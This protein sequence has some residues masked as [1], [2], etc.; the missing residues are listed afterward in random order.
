MARPG[1]SLGSCFPLQDDGGTALRLGPTADGRDLVRTPG[2]PT[3]LL[4]LGA[5]PVHSR[6]INGCIR[7]M[8]RLKV[9]LKEKKKMRYRGLRLNRTRVVGVADPRSGA[10]WLYPD[11]ILNT[12]S[13]P[14]QNKTKNH[15][16]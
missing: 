9:V 12:S 7:L 16:V 5:F 13:A 4:A 3:R 8:R 14:K 2:D 10:E 6:V 1:R 15:P 11:H